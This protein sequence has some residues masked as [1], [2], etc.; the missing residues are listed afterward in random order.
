MN[1]MNP[2]Y[3]QKTEC[4]DCYKCVRVCQFKA[5]KIEDGHAIVIP[6]ACV[7]CGKCVSICPAKA[8][9]VRNDLV[10]ATYLLSTGKKVIVSLAPS[11]VAEFGDDAKNIPGYLKALGFYG[12]SE[13]AIGAEIVSTALPDVMVKGK[14]NISS[15]CPVVVEVIRKYYPHLSDR[16]T[17]ILSPALT[18]AR[19]LK[20]RFGNDTEIV[21]IGPCIAKK[22]EADRHPD[23]IALSLSFRD[24]AE[25]IA[26]LTP[27]QKAVIDNSFITERSAAG[28]LY[29]VEGG[30]LNT[31]K[32][33]CSIVDEK[34]LAFAGIGEVRMVLDSLEKM[35]NGKTIL[36][37]LMAC[38]G[39][40]IN[41]PL[42]ISKDSPL[43]KRQTVIEQSS[44]LDMPD[45]S[46]TAAQYEESYK[47][48]PIPVSSFTEEELTA[49]LKSIGKT[50]SEDMLNCAGCGYD[51]CRE[52]ATAILRGKAE[53]SMCAS[54]MRRLAQKKANALI[55]SMPS[56][57]VITDEKLNIIECNSMFA[58]Q[59]IEE[60][61][62]M[63]SARPGLEGASLTKILPAQ[64]CD[65]FRK[66]TVSS[67]GLFEADALI[68]SSF[69]HCTVFSIEKN[70]AAGGIFQ[71]VTSPMMQKKNVVEKT[72]EVISKN[73][74]TVQTIA[75][76]LGEN[77]ANTE[78]LLNSIIESY[79]VSGDSNE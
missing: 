43:I 48:L 45:T 10:R 32:K 62:M 17:S 67:N 11:Y 31:L 36:L 78:V 55:K 64:I 5:I 16:I 18:H 70:H 33:N 35:E 8:K 74:E 9:K 19:E 22:S 44:S 37:E 40:C 52:F 79:K 46:V 71:D 63:L 29:P 60:G 30:L 77:A 65:M 27:A 56:G 59:M 25:M 75:A 26:T 69:F 53:R 66:V 57:V 72:R 54:Y 6:E 2:I 42:C 50:S 38:R 58:G 3:T 76:L 21:F 61:E 7:E 1:I 28:N 13:T 4:Q 12:V 41:G 14:I 47:P 39:G 51:S 34:Y 49:A 73:L 24:L 20:R 68:G 23:L 15:A